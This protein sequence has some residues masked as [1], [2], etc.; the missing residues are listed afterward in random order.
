[1]CSSHEDAAHNYPYI[2]HRAVHRSQYGPED[3]TQAGYVQ[4]LDHEYTPALHGYIV[5]AVIFCESGGRPRRV[6][7]EKSLGH[8]SI[9]KK[10]QDEQSDRY[11][12][13]YH[14]FLFR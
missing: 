5:N 2:H 3:R 1:M 6:H 13:G 9:D 11:C 14:R 10:S 4:E 7:P 8:F 12:Q